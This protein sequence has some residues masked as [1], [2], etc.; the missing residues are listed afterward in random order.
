MLNEKVFSKE[1]EIPKYWL[2][3]GCTT[4]LAEHADNCVQND[5]RLIQISSRAFDEYVLCV[6]RKLCMI[7]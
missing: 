2:P 3:V 1:V 7:A 4:I 5:L 6:Q